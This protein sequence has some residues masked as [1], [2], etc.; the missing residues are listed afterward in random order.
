M[1]HITHEETARTF[2]THI[3]RSLKHKILEHAEYAFWSKY[4]NFGFKQGS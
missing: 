3:E 1:T 2:K 4:I